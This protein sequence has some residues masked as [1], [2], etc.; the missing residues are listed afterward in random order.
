MVIF[1]KCIFEI[2]MKTYD[3]R[4]KSYIMAINLKNISLALFF[5]CGGP[6]E[7][8]FIKFCAYF[9]A[10][11]GNFEGSFMA[12]ECSPSML[13]KAVQKGGFYRT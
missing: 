1:A 5:G 10:E 8:T 9:S 4:V 13:L 2:T 6:L 11:E 12:K 3:W 7:M